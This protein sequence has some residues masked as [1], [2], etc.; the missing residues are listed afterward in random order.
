MALRSKL[1][2]GGVAAVDLFSDELA[3][4]AGGDFLL[5]LHAAGLERQSLV[6]D[7]LAEPAGVVAASEVVEPRLVIDPVGELEEDP[8]ILGPKIE[9]PLRSAKEEALV[10]AELALRIFSE[11]SLMRGARQVGSDDHRLKTFRRPPGERFAGLELMPR[12]AR[13]IPTRRHGE[14]RQRGLRG[15]A[16]R[17]R[18]INP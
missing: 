12:D 15:T 13:S 4:L 14:R 18:H 7:R 16:Q 17:V 1:G 5:G 3:A 11:M 9:L 10:Q 2:W 8:E 6:L